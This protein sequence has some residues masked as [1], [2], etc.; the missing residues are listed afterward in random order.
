MQKLN[1]R[2]LD[3]KSC[4]YNICKQKKSH[5]IIGRST[6]KWPV[7]PAKTQIS[8]GIHPPSLISLCCALTGCQ[9]PQGSFM[10][11]AK[12]GGCPGWSESLWMHVILMVLSCCGSLICL[13]PDYFINRS[14]CW[15][16][17]F[18]NTNCEHTCIS[19]SFL[20]TFALCFS[21]SSLSPSSVCWAWAFTLSK[22]FIVF[23]RREDK[24]PSS[25]KQKCEPQHYK[26]NKMICGPSEDS[27]QPWRPPRLISLRS[28]LNG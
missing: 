27:D 4:K 9:G 13:E 21:S 17:N 19:L 2:K 16:H 6:K 3:N 10:R 28:A 12:M 26:T 14:Q 23:S 20:P 1:L 24:S 8:L 25:L 18:S 22:S 11:P 15:N 5:K 7:H